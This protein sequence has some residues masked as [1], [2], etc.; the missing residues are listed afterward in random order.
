MKQIDIDMKTKR[1]DASILPLESSSIL[2]ETKPPIPPDL[3]AQLQANEV[4]QI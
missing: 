4:L 3:M 2:N 1:P